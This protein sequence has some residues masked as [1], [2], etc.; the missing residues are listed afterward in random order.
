[1]MQEVEFIVTN[2]KKDLDAKIQ[3]LREFIDGDTHM[4]LPIGEKERLAHQLYHMTHYSAVLQGRID[5]F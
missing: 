3:L 2:E 4:Q 1:M 5:A